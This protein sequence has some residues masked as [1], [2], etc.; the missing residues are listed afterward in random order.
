MSSIVTVFDKAFVFLALE[1]NWN[2]WMNVN[3]PSENCECVPSKQGH[4]KPI[5]SNVEPSFT[6]VNDHTSSD[7]DNEVNRGWVKAGIQ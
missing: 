6:D 2:G 7:G 3:K 5:T 4:S 1:N